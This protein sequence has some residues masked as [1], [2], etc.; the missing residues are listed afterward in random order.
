MAGGLLG[1]EEV[2]LVM[3]LL[4]L[5]LAE[6][7]IRELAGEV[8]SLQEEEGEE[9]QLEEGEGGSGLAIGCS[10]SI[11]IVTSPRSCQGGLHQWCTCALARR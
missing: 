8:D 5:D 1:E 2:L 10:P 9:E 7:D 3:S 6:A 4:L 11:I